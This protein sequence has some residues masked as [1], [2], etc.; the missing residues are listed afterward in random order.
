M[1]WRFWLALLPWVFSW[2]LGYLTVCFQS[3]VFCW[4]NRRQLQTAFV[5]FSSTVN[6]WLSQYVANANLRMFIQS[7]FRPLGSVNNMFDNCY[8]QRHR[9]CYVWGG[10]LLVSRILGGQVSWEMS[11]LVLWAQS[12]ADDYIRADV[13]RK[14][15]FLFDMKLVGRFKTKS[16]ISIFGRGLLLLIR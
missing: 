14:T 15:N 3:V 8:F 5:N 16:L 9:C 4:Y 6:H 2:R 11:E 7:S 10:F 1:A 12:T 13:T